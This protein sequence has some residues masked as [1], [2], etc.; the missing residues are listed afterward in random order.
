L[1]L[2]SFSTLNPRSTELAAVSLIGAHPETGVLGELSS[3][4]KVEAEER[5][6]IALAE[7]Q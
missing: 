2:L 4:G 1:L 7:I 6:F 3:L 5:S